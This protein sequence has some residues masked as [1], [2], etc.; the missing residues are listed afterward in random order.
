MKKLIL[1]LLIIFTFA[2][3]EMTT[4]ADWYWIGPD[5]SGS[6]WYIDNQSATKEYGTATVWVKIVRTNGTYD[7]CQYKVTK[8]KQVAGVQFIT[9]DANN[10]VINSSSVYPVFETIAPESMGDALYRLI[11]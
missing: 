10:V 7:L 5:S 1:A 9:Y 3:T 11:W 2:G 6:Q 8:D 4:A